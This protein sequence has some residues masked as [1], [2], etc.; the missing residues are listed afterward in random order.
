VLKALA[1]ADA[2]LGDLMFA[3]GDQQASMPF[4]RNAMRQFGSI[5][6]SD[7]GNTSKAR[8]YAQ[9]AN[10]VG[11][12]ALKMNMLSEALSM[13][14]TAETTIRPAAS[15][16]DSEVG[17]LLDLAKTL[18]GLGETLEK[19]KQGDQAKASYKEARQLLEQASQTEKDNEEAA[20]GLADIIVKT[21]RM[22]R[23]SNDIAGSAAETEKAVEIL[24]R[25]V[26]RP[27]S[28]SDYRRQL[29]VALTMKGELA[30][31]Q[32]KTT[33]AQE[34]FEEAIGMWNSYGR[35][36]GLKPEE[37]IEIDRLKTLSG[38]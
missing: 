33:V 24:R 15:K 26:A 21:A 17:P 20:E 13:F 31:A 19:S 32:R 37:E 12:K 10:N 14:R 18:S 4:A 22:S 35:L 9:S 36:A 28:K 30:R 27:A 25:L 8:D 1:A 7:K 5:F 2:A 23:E 29:A 38:R 34:A 16:P 6:E 11:G 3:S